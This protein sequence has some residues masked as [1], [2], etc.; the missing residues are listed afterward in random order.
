MR[1]SRVDRVCAY[2]GIVRE[3]RTCIRLG[4]VLVGLLVGAMVLPQTTS[5]WGA[6]GDSHKH[7]APSS[8]KP[9]LDAAKKLYVD[10]KSKFEGGDFTG[11]LADF[12]A[13][14][15]IKATPQAERYIGRCLDAL[16]RYAEAAEYYE[17]FLAHAP[18]KM[19]GQAERTHVRLEE[20]RAASDKGQTHPNPPAAAVAVDGKRQTAASP[21]PANDAAT[22]ADSPQPALSDAPVS[23]D[24]LAPASGESVSPPSVS[25]P[26]SR[27]PVYLTAGAA[28]ISAGVGTMF[29]VM[30]LSDKVTF[31]R[32]STTQNA[33]T[34]NT[35]A[36]M[37]DVS[38]G[39]ALSLAALSA[40]LFFTSSTQ[41]AE[42]DSESTPSSA[43]G[44][45]S[46]TH[47]ITVAPTPFV[48][49]HA[50]GAGLFLRF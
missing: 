6:P 30:A 7:G 40:V 21:V 15:D 3:K 29:G 50:G 1:S 19:A 37:A 26:H 33:S 32:N 14:N 17:K 34:R 36:L 4:P 48:G 42:P 2:A 23:A 8:A 41:P 31:D 46:R 13:A 12:Q 27:L 24:L 44:G 9:D 20:M 22:P 10:G 47:A 38:F 39:A 18:A 43:N 45:R 16:G 25:T 28:I 35:H 49:P 11:A 5:A